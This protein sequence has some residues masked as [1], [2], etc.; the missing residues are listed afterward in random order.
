[1]KSLLSCAVL[2]VSVSGGAV[3]AATPQPQ[4]GE[5]KISLAEPVYFNLSGYSDSAYYEISSVAGTGQTPMK[6]DGA[7]LWIFTRTDTGSFSKSYRAVRVQDVNQMRRAGRGSSDPVLLNTKEEYAAGKRTM[8]SYP[9]AALLACEPGVT[10][11]VKAEG[12]VQ[13][14]T[15]HGTMFFDRSDVK[16]GEVAKITRAD[17]MQ[18]EVIVVTKK[19][20]DDL[21]AANANLYAMS[22]ESKRKSDEDAKKSQTQ[23]LAKKEA[24]FRSAPRGTI[25]SCTTGN[26]IQP[27]AQPIS[28]MTF[29]CDEIDVRTFRELLQAGWAV[30]MTERIPTRATDGFEGVTVNIMIKK[31]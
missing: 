2:A 22:Q 7:V 21:R 27:A 5:Q 31:Q 4:A 19:Q 14:E 1:M 25:D 3:H 6:S 12:C 10:P 30:T 16:P 28:K 24:L 23:M 15:L 29:I 13:P 18:N 8:A 11:T 9:I 20:Y 17:F 26:F